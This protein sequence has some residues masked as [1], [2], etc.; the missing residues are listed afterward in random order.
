MI[1]NCYIT[2]LKEVKKFITNGQLILNKSFSFER[3]IE[4]GVTVAD[5]NRVTYIS[6]DRKILLQNLIDEACGY[7]KNYKSNFVKKV[8]YLKS[9][10]LSV[11]EICKKLNVS[12]HFVD[13]LLK[14][15]EEMMRKSYKL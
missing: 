4:S 5:K 13:D 1:S 8:I 7:I 15:V 11:T 6:D 12:R 14:D 10:G 2:T 9:L 3:Y